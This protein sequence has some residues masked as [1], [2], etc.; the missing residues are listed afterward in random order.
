MIFDTL[1]QLEN[2]TTQEQAIVEYIVENPQSV[3]DMSISELAKAS[4]TSNSTIVRLCQKAGYSGY[5]EL[6]KVFTLEYPSFMKFEKRLR[7]QPFDST[8]NIDDI[9]ESLSL[10][11]AKTME[12]TR[13]MLHRPTLLKCIEL[14]GECA[15][16][17][18]YGDGLN[19]DIARMYAYKF[20]EVGINAVAYD[21]AHWQHLRRLSLEGVPTFSILL[22]HTG[23]NPNIVSIANRLKDYGLPTLAIS[24]ITE[25]KTLK[26]LCTYHM[27]IVVSRNTTELS[28]HL[29]GFS[30]QYIL[31]VMV[32]AM[33]SK[34]FE[35]IE[36]I[37][38][39]T[40]HERSEWNT[41]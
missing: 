24:G 28:N 9:L 19:F 27:S 34:N 32:M 11:N 7:K 40:T 20:E 17:G 21:S 4:F 41:D 33:L 1:K 35:M 14:L 3:L 36:K 12:Y 39:L 5:A 8:T 16:L 22:S 23:K 6:K 2:L 38:Q 25:D 15:H 10:I 31:D 30:T 26:N 18:I 13:S 37:A 29:F